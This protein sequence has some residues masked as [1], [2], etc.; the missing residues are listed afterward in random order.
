MAL[1]SAENQKLRAGL[2]RALARN[3]FEVYYQPLVSFQNGELDGF[4]ALIRW[5]SKELGFIMPVDFIP[6]AEETGLIVPIGE[7]ILRQA[8]REIGL[9]EQQLGRDFILSVNLSP[10]QMQQADLSAARHAGSRR[11]H[12]IT[13][14]V[15]TRNYREPSHERLWG[16]PK[17]PY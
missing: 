17:Y 2:E 6:I 16:R 14:S 5:R 3:E 13:P 7:W 1:A 10:R 11:G 9:L 4:E 15:G 12:P 8:C